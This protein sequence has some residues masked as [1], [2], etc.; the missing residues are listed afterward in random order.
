MTGSELAT[1]SGSGTEGRDVYGTIEVIT[2][3]AV[4]V[5]SFAIVPG[6]GVT[7]LGVKI[8]TE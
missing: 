3:A 2:D 8:V 1:G 6:A 4:G 5:S 7:M